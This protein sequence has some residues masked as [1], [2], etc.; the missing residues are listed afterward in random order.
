MPHKPDPQGWYETKTCVDHLQ[1]GLPVCLHEHQLAV[2]GHLVS[3]QL[4]CHCCHLH[5]TDQIVSTGCLEWTQLPC[6]PR[7]SGADCCT[8]VLTFPE[9]F[10]SLSERP[11]LTDTANN[12]ESQAQHNTNQSYT[13]R[14]I[15]D[16]SRS[17]CL[18]LSILKVSCCSARPSTELRLSLF[19]RKPSG[20]SS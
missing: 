8:D 3:C 14:L 11:T 18:I 7:R 5:Q 1:M 9:T 16:T 13:R 19:C 4:L 15:V 12:P 2:T 10:C 6:G 17:R 20:C